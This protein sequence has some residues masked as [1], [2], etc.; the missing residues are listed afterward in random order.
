[1]PRTIPAAEFPSLLRPGRRVWVGAGSNE[2]LALLQALARQPDAARGVTF[3][4]FPLPGL[5]RFDF[6][7]LDPGADMITFFMTPELRRSRGPASCPC[8]CASCSSTCGVV[9]STSRSSKWLGREDGGL[10]CGPNADFVGAALESAG[11]VVAEL[12]LGLAAPAGG[13]RIAEDRVDYLVESHRPATTVEAGEPDETARRIGARVAALVRAGDCI[14]TGIGAIP[15]AI[16]H[17]LGDRNDLGLH[18]GLIDDGG[19]A[20]I[21]AGNITGARKTVD[22]GAACDRLGPRLGTP[23]RVARRASGRGVRRCRP[24]P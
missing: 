9:R 17:A 20:L 11:L 3:L 4:Q 6:T 12:N 14:Q 21:E 7:A 2:P 19:M 24:H 23:P 18:G 16:L 22:V 15:M 13:M 5:N 10:V 8:R 1:M